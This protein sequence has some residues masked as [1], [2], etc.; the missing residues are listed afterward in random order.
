[1]SKTP[2]PTPNPKPWLRLENEPTKA[3]DAFLSYLFMPPSE[4]SLATVSCRQPDGQVSAISKRT[5]ERYSTAWN[6]V[7]RVNAYD[8][9]RAAELFVLE[10]DV[11][12]VMSAKRIQ[13]QEAFLET[14]R[15]LGAALLKKVELMLEFPLEDTMIHQQHPDG[16]PHVTIVKAAR[17]NF[18]TVATLIETYDVV[19]RAA[20]NLPPA[21][22]FDVEGLAAETVDEILSA[23]KAA[24]TAEQYDA[25][26]DELAR[27][28]LG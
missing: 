25:L 14:E 9:H 21:S 7:E 17:W 10:E 12:R 22:S 20:L 3:Y 2:I 13:A 4:R 6:W 16:Q 15:Q 28:N 18:G 19:T 5:F 23:A 27:Q 8:D 24:L 1:M 26:L 11:T